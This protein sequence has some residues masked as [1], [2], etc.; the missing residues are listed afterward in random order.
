MRI[1]SFGSCSPGQL[2]AKDA[3]SKAL[4]ETQKDREGNVDP[5]VF[6]QPRVPESAKHACA[7]AMSQERDVGLGLILDADQA[8]RVFIEQL[9]PSSIAHKS[10]Q[11]SRAELHAFPYESMQTL[12]ERQKSDHAGSSKSQP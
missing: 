12:C 2:R 7:A 6:F 4:T 10:G 8:G 11:V 1:L 5:P 3:E 9:L